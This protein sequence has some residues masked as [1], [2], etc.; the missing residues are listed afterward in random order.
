MESKQHY[1]NPDRPIPYLPPEQHMDFLIAS[2]NQ[3]MAALL[4]TLKETAAR[5]CEALRIL[6]D[7][8][9][10]INKKIPIN[11]PA[12]GCNA[13]ILDMSDKLFGMLMNL[14]RDNRKRLFVYKNS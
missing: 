4:Q 13:R 9:D 6:W 7:E 5:P 8:L 3:E 14:P 10:F 1:Q 12:K 11:H 2:C